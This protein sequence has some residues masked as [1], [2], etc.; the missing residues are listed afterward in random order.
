MG[1]VDDTIDGPTKKK[2]KDDMTW[3]EVFDLGKRYMRIPAVLIVVEVL[4]WFL[5]QPSNTLAIIQVVEAWIWHNCNI[6]LFGE[7]SS[8]LSTHNGWWTKVT[9]SHPNFYLNR[10][11]LFVSDEC[12]GVHEM[13]FISTLVILTDGVPQKLKIKSVAVLSSI[14]FLLNIVRLVLLYPMARMGCDNNPNGSMC[15]VPMWEFHYIVYEWGFLI[16][17][18]LIWTCWFYFIG[19]PKRV[20]KAA[21]LEKKPIYLEFQVS[22][23]RSSLMLTIGQGS[24]AIDNNAVLLR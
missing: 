10:I 20:R 2:P 22:D 19:G 6:I 5:T 15:E 1:S 18:V 11:D 23:P 21:A 12:A 7:G 24:S 17:L 8:M 13:L 14:V 16:I 4:Y 9:L 3:S